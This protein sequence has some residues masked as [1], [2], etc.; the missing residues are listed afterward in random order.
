MFRF[1]LFLYFSLI[2][3]VASAQEGAKELFKKTVSSVY[4]L[5]A[6][7]NNNQPQSLGTGFAV[8]KHMIATN[9]H[10]IHNSFKIKVYQT[11]SDKELKVIGIKGFDNKRDLALIEID[12]DLTPLKLYTGQIDVGE[13]VFSIGN[14]QGLEATLSSGI[15]SS[16]RK[17][18]DPNLYQITAP[19]S[20]GSS[21]GPV[22]LGNGEVI[23][24]ATSYLESG[25]N[26]NF[27]VQSQYLSRLIFFSSLKTPVDVSQCSGAPL[28]EDAKPALSS[29]RIVKPT[30]RG[31][32]NVEMGNYIEF[33]LSVANDGDKTISAVDLMIF[34]YDGPD[35][36]HTLRRTLSTDVEPKLAERQR[37]YVTKLKFDTFSASSKWTIQFRV[38]GFSV[39]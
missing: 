14:P 39:K 22:M 9:Y 2:V 31:S 27:A 26:L 10:V 30:F 33:N 21:G 36:I 3:S 35:L 18:E 6:F 16:V 8:G 25:Q 4:L 13:L 32:L 19:I 12:A 34:I 7:D 23:G 28:Q 37:F 15:V 24:V 11:G 20:P 17:K 5:V 38:L 1:V 29:V